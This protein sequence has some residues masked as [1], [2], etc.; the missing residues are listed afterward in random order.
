MPA[1]DVKLS[2]VND[3]I[4]E[5]SRT[6]VIDTNNLDHYCT[7]NYSDSLGAMELNGILLLIKRLKMKYK[8]DIN[9]DY[10][11][12]EIIQK[13]RNTYLMQNTNLTETRILEVAYHRT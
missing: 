9:L 4:V 10:V 1:H 5:D 13:R 8:G 7:K 2:A 6:G 12:T 3:G 11:V